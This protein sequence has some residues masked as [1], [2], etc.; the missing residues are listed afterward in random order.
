MIGFG[1]SE[2][3]NYQKQCAVLWT[4]L[5][6]GKRQAGKLLSGMPEHWLCSVRE[7][8][9]DV[10]TLSFVQESGGPYIYTHF[11]KEMHKW[12]M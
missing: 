1:I 12:L 2:P 6:A 10:K 7:G 3:C 8:G 5:D 4:V 11:L 9:V